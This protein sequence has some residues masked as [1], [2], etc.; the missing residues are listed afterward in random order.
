MKIP[1][2]KTTF[3]FENKEE[4]LDLVFQVIKLERVSLLNTPA[5]R[6]YFVTL[7]LFSNTHFYCVVTLHLVPYNKSPLYT[8]IT[9]GLCPLLIFIPFKSELRAFYPK[10]STHQPQIKGANYLTHPNQPPYDHQLS[11]IKQVLAFSCFFFFIVIVVLRRFLHL[12]VRYKTWKTRPL[13]HLPHCVQL[14]VIIVRWCRS[15]SS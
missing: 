15:S 12:E 11:T 1:F 14:C 10:L 8:N 13:I 6:F 2:I 5:C 4:Q 7:K 3:W 9:A